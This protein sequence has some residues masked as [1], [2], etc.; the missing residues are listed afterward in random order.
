ML[1]YMYVNKYCP[2]IQIWVIEWMDYVIEPNS[3]W[4][5]N[6]EKLG[7]NVSNHDSW[8]SNLVY[9]RWALSWECPVPQVIWF[10]RDQHYHKNVL[11]HEYSE[12][13][14]KAKENGKARKQMNIDKQF[15]RKYEIHFH[16]S[17]IVK[18]RSYENGFYKLS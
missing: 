6:C 13:T 7:I 9:R 14:S 3:S 10:I 15:W 17:I 18:I 4:T 8:T 1:R 5:M 12:I 11:C 16:W 2:Y